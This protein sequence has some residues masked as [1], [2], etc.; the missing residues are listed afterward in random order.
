MAFKHQ[1][2][3]DLSAGGSWLAEPGTYHLL[4][5]DVQEEVTKK[6]GTLVPDAAFRVNCSVCNGTMSGQLDK[7]TDIVFFHPKSDQKNE[8][9]MARK[10]MDRFFVAVGLMTQQQV[11]TK[12]EVEIDLQD[13]VGRQF[14]A[15]LVKEK[16]DSQFLSLNFADI[17]HVDDPAV[18]DIPKSQAHLKLIEPQL[19]LA[20]KAFE[21]AKPASNKGSNG[22]AKRETKPAAAAVATS[23]DILSDL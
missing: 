17:F 11:E 6:D 18:K 14:V 20:S 22:A 3:G 2:G 4:I 16:A 12:A 13:A 9:A 7:T 5:T 10:K 19:R 8:G 23:D 15:K 1:A 21:A